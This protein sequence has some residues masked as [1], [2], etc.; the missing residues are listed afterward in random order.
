MHEA[1]SLLQMQLLMAIDDFAS[2]VNQLRLTP[3][4][5]HTAGAMHQ[6]RKGQLS[7]QFT[8]DKVLGFGIQT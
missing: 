7:A 3:E 1:A 6:P 5:V 8:N 2:F 4:E